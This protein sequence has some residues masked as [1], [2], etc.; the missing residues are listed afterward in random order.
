MCLRFLRSPV[1][2]D[3]WPLL[4][5]STLPP[6][7]GLLLCLLL[8]VE[9]LTLLGLWFQRRKPLPQEP[10]LWLQLVLLK[11]LNLGR[12]DLLRNPAKSKK[13]QRKSNPVSLT[14]QVTLTWWLQLAVMISKLLRTPKF[15]SKSTMA[16]WLVK[17]SVAF[18][19]LL[20]PLGEKQFN[21]EIL[22]V[23]SL[24]RQHKAPKL[25]GPGHCQE[26]HRE[27]RLLAGLPPTM[28]KDLIWT[29]YWKPSA[30]T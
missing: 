13:N 24:L 5:V 30:R 11:I 21:L 27:M 15:S 12:G 23:R 2:L 25:L 29:P 9:L 10:G 28:W 8:P 26:L 19:L 7:L 14:L 3:G 16:M 17:A 4:L 18:Q 22:I 6:N 20:V 1:V